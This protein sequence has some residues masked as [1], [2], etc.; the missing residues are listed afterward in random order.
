M[1]KKYKIEVHQFPH[2]RNEPYII[3]VETDDVKWS[4]DQILR[5]RLPST[6]RLVE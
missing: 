2:S 3:E 6:C 1:K 4:M 5:N